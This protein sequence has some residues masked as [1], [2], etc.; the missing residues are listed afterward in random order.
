M[1]QRF[2][3]A[4]LLVV[5]VLID[6]PRAL[7]QAAPDP[8]LKPPVPAGQRA[9]LHFADAEAGM[10][11]QVWDAVQDSRG[12]LIVLEGYKLHR[13]D[14][15]N[16]RSFSLP[17]YAQHLLIDERDRLYVGGPKD[18]GYINLEQDSASFVS[19]RDLL[20]EDA[21]DAGR[22]FGIL[23]FKQGV[24]FSTQRGLFLLQGE[25]GLK[26]LAK[27]ETASFERAFLWQ[28]RL[29][30]EHLTLGLLE[31]PDGAHGEAKPGGLQETELVRVIGAEALV[32][33]KLSALLPY[34][35]ASALLFAA[36]QGSFRLTPEGLEEFPL[37][38]ASF[39]RDKEFT[40]GIRTSDGRFVLGTT[41]SGVVVLNARGELV[42]SLDQEHHPRLNNSIYE[43]FEDR[44]GNLWICTDLGVAMVPRSP[45]RYVVDPSQVEGTLHRTHRH[46][47]R[48]YIGT[49][50]GLY[51]QVSAPSVTAPFA[52]ENV[53]EVRSGVWDLLSRGDDLLV[54][55]ENGILALLDAE[56]ALRVETICPS[57][58]ES[59]HPS[60]LFS[61]RIFFGTQEGLK[62]L[63]RQD[64]KWVCSEPIH[65]LKEYVFR[66]A[67]THDGEL[68]LRAPGPLLYRLR[69]PGGLEHPPEVDR[70]ELPAGSNQLLEIEGEIFLSNAEGN[71]R[72]QGAGSPGVFP[73]ENDATFSYLRSPHEE[74]TPLLLKYEAD[75]GHLWLATPEAQIDIATRSSPTARFERR[76]LA[77][78]QLQYWCTIYRDPE[79]EV[80][81]LTNGGGVKLVESDFERMGPPTQAVLSQALQLQTNV[82]LL[83]AA[84][85]EDG[86]PP[87][88]AF[89]DNSLQFDF[90][91]PVFDQLGASEYQWKLEGFDDE[92]SPWSTRTSKEYTNLWEKT[93]RF[94]VRARDRWG[95]PTEEA[96]FVFR[97]APPIYRTP[98]AY[99]LYVLSLV[100]ALSLALRIHRRSIDRERAIN[101][102]LR[103]VDKL[104]DEFLANTSH[105]LRTP[106]FGMTGLAESMLDGSAGE[107]PEAAKANLSMIAA[108]GRRL[109]HLVGD[110]LDLSK[111]RHQSLQLDPRAVHL[112]SLVDVVLTLSASLVGTKALR[113]EN[114]LHADLPA[115]KADEYR[116]QQILYNLLGNAIK[117]SEEGTIEVSARTLE[118]EEL[119]EVSVRDPG[120]GIPEEKQEEIFQPFE[121]GDASVERTYGGTGLGLAVTRQLV[122]LHGGTIWVEATPGEGSTF[123]FTLPM[124]GAGERVEDSTV[125]AMP[126]TVQLGAD[127]P[128][129]P[130]VASPNQGEP[131]T[132]ALRILAVDD[133]P[134]NLQVLKNYLAREPY[135]LVTA[136]SGDEA[137]QRI[138]EERFDLVLLDVMMPKVSGFEVCRAL[139]KNRSM[140]DLPVLFLTA[141]NQVVDLVTGLSLGANDFLTK[142]VSKGELLARM[143]PHLD[144]LEIHRHLEDVVEEKMSEIKVLEGIL[145]ICSVCKKI[146]D[147]DGIWKEMELFIDTHSEAQFSHGACPECAGKLYPSLLE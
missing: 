90:A 35:D 76:R 143:R 57:K 14:G 55:S 49:R 116:L 69:F 83:T 114:K 121:Q 120:I 23:P 47:G 98:W 6:L 91:A 64:G 100:L 70:Y 132:D 110:I 46:L 32:G 37:P 79:H 145:R 94:R 125:S 44:Q 126:R 80:Y 31:L 62:T 92:W 27:S 24:L 50:T 61:G 42:E 45:A 96:S 136:S 104:K 40:E 81:W 66:I 38:S 65:E 41:R 89:Q 105:E 129:L 77:A 28:A 95:E 1:A 86:S 107:L 39:L 75:R 52:V 88:L 128:D 112:R 36:Q 119:V 134:V 109:T 26:V 111:M 7:A 12:L 127:R 147:E 29:Y 139:R 141:K 131:P 5:L 21:R 67:E 133:E 13:F 3:L 34:D 33:A 142:P 4:V 101:Q 25:Q 135:D 53:P 87:I 58:A 9:V 118:Q 8:S 22:V 2:L 108:S 123:S 140:A 10:M 59:L 99:G 19:A 130:A 97:V 51:R 137:L 138:E 93:Y 56:G 73:F 60:R 68:L 11:S 103:E 54:A 106:L 30:V 63:F 48:L 20:P 122:E 146:R 124:A 78:D 144:L 15:V 16:W 17:I 18:F 117:F 82:D 115:V 72:Y 84:P 74:A 102:R 71:F 43:V 85:A 113:L